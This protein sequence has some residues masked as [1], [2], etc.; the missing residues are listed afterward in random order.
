MDFTGERFIPSISGEE[1]EIEHMQRYHFAALS[2]KDKI[3]LD[4]ACGEGYGSALLAEHA[5]KVYGI[6]ISED[7]V[8]NAREKYKSERL[9]FRCASIEGIPLEDNSVDCVVSFETIEHVDDKIQHRFMQEI[10][11]VLKP[12]GF[13]LMSTPNKR[14]YTDLVA[15]ENSFHVKE[16]YMQE[17]FDFL[18]LYFKE[19]KI[20]SQYFEVCSVI[21]NNGD[22]SAT[23]NSS[24]AQE[25]AKYFI[26]LCSDVNLNVPLEDS[27]V[28]SNQ[29]LYVNNALRIVELQG[30]VEERNAHIFKLDA[31]IAELSANI[32]NLK[33]DMQGQADKFTAEKDALVVEK[34]A[35]ITEKSKLLRD[36]L[37]FED[38][39]QLEK[40]KYENMCI[41]KQQ[42]YELCMH[43]KGVAEAIQNS[44]SY[45]L[46]Q[47][48]S[49]VLVPVGSRRRDFL[50]RF[51]RIFR[52]GSKEAPQKQNIYLPK[53]NHF[54]KIQAPEFDFVEVSIVIPVYNQ[55]EYTYH[56][57]DSIIK[58]TAG[59]KYEIIV[60]D[61]VSSDRTKVIGKYIKNINVIRNEK[62]LGFLLNCN[63]AAKAAKGEYILFLNNDTQVE[64]NWLK[65][66]TDLMKRDRQVGIAGSQLIGSDGLLQEAGG[67]IWKDA[68]GWNFGLGNPPELPEYNY[69]KEVD[70]VSGASLMIRKSLWEEIG[71]FDTRY[72]PAYFEDS[73]LAFEVRKHGYKVV[74]QPLSKVIHFEGVSNG[75]SEESGI[76]SYQ[77]IN[78]EKFREKWNSELKKA[79]FSNA[80]DVF[81]ARDRSRDKKSVLIIDHYVPEYDRDAGSRTIFQYI[82][83]LTDMGYNVKFL[84][85]NFA[86]KQPYTGMLEQMGVEVLYG[87]YYCQNWRQWLQEN[88]KYIDYVLLNRPHIARNYID[89]I[90][91]YTTAKIAYYVV[92][93]HFLREQRQ[94]EI[95]GNP[96]LLQSSQM[97]KRVE[98]DLMDKADVV[99]TLSIDEKK[100]I[101]ELLGENK[102]EINP[103]FCYSDFD[104]EPLDVKG[105]RDILFVGGFAHTPNVDGVIW[106]LEKILPEIVK[107]IPDIRFF[108]VGSNPPEELKKYESNHVRLLGFVDDETLKGLY[109]TCRVCV[110]PLRFGAGIKG[111][112]IE[113]MYNGISIVSTSSGIEG[114]QD[115]EQYLCACDDEKRFADEVVR[116]YADESAIV[117]NYKKYPAYVKRFFSCDSAK[118]FFA[119]LF[120]MKKEERI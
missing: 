114:L 117:E 60:A 88:G 52:P 69:V 104:L 96:E 90:K 38:K 20:Y 35:L 115:I 53:R 44:R 41:Q 28:I 116:L 74:Y 18:H 61:D 111:K 9:D 80:Q 81:Y 107:E 76:K 82:E 5:T 77:K 11:R 65:P 36:V 39:L 24:F 68:T 3:V 110:I 29:N 71:G 13:L 8:E 106:F 51:Y 22:I 83:I 59:V 79:H 97:W 46:T 70:Y 118:A 4:A 45:R 27:V 62:N 92:D 72:E 102:T 103:I 42:N 25:N 2:V 109:Q 43:Y 23:K 64:E 112:T 1:I 26:A 120:P 31:H 98:Q 55:F 54:G 75:T 85:D 94:Y 12:D 49:K 32:E 100:M 33:S 89:V 108:I 93:L 56:C 95:T 19:Y 7:A 40:E 105:K 10:K 6:D 87:E 91:E 15:Q 66:L 58:N 16:F 113:A 86:A 30:E 17:F 119:K 50:K 48:F 78:R 67:V 84:G 99:L 14:V 21:E 34:R 37:I 47:K 57:I 101:D 73:D 63:H